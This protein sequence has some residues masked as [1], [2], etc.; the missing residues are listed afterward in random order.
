MTTANV[1]SDDDFGAAAFDREDAEAL[2]DEAQRGMGKTVWKP[3][4][5]ATVFR[6]LPGLT[7][8]PL[9]GVGAFVVF[10]QHDLDVPGKGSVFF[11]CPE[12]MAQRPCPQCA[13]ARELKARAL[14]SGNEADDDMAFR[15]RAK[16]K[17]ACNVLIRGE[18]KNGP[19]VWMLSSGGEKSLHAK[20]LSFRQGTFGG[21]FASPTLGYDLELTRSGTGQND[22]T[23]SLA[24]NPQTSRLL[25]TDAEIRAVL[26]GLHDLRRFLVVPTDAEVGKILKGEKVRVRGT[27]LH[28]GGAPAGHLPAPGGLQLPAKPVTD[29]YAGLGPYGSAPGDRPDFEG[30]GTDEDI[31]F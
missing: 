15:L 23:Y 26:A 27:G 28:G 20:L 1:G 31:P 14:Q 9:A 16:A 17:A 4:E 11:N 5:G 18:E 13:K 30:G 2:L 19:K 7:K 12:M 25:P 6:V 29:G 8:G 24:R 22:T 10:H 3:R 21:D